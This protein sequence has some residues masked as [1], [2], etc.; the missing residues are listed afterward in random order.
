MRRDFC[1]QL[2]AP[3]SGTKSFLPPWKWSEGFFHC[4]LLMF[5]H[6]DRYSN[7]F[8]MHS[9][10]FQSE[11]WKIRWLAFPCED[12]FLYWRGWEAIRCPTEE[13][14]LTSPWSEVQKETK[15]WPSWECLSFQRFP[16]IFLQPDFP[17]QIFVSDVEQEQRMTRALLREGRTGSRL[18][19][20]FP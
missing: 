6:V 7:S 10:T 9:F 11:K 13:R 1:D 18:P 4:T 19:F 17:S 8:R 2:I 3:S 16:L 5:W 20:W 12:I 14:M 15:F